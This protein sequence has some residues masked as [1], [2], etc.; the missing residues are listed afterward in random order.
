MLKIVSR[1]LIILLAAGGVCAGLYLYA[2][3][4]G[5]S[6]GGLRGGDMPGRLNFDGGEAFANGEMPAPPQF[7]G[8]RTLDGGSLAA[9]PEG[10]F[11]HN[12]RGRGEE[13][14]SFFNIVGIFIN[15]GKVAAITVLVILVQW[16]GT[17]L[18]HRRAVAPAA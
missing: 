13:G 15:L 3:S 14:G 5:A 2:N 11:R 1:I 12:G 17:K 8:S 9:R 4:A 10:A 18:F 7:D 6:L 16:A